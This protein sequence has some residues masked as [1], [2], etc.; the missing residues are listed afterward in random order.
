MNSS[1]KF[2][3]PSVTGGL[4]A[5][6]LLDEAE[7]VEVLL[8]LWVLE[9]FD[10]LPQAA[11]AIAK[12]SALRPAVMVLVMVAPWSLVWSVQAVSTTGAMVPARASCPVSFN[13]LGVSAR[14]TPASTSS[15]TRAR[16]AMQIAAPRTPER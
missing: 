4:P 14:C 12:T 3:S 11:T 1:L 5:P 9:L 15:T 2:L 16:A 10:E 7:L 6:G 13:P 8:E